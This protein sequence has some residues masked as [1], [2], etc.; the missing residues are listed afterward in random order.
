MIHLIRFPAWL[1][2][3]LAGAIITAL[4]VPLLIPYL[5]WSCYAGTAIP[6]P[7]APLQVILETFERLWPCKKGNA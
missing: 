4:G 1:L 6:D 5:L 7:A 2:L 3:W